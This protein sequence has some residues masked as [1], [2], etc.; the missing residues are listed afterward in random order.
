MINVINPKLYEAK[1]GGKGLRFELE[2]RNAE[3]E[4]GMAVNGCRVVN[5]ALL[6]P[7]ITLKT[8]RPYAQVKFHGMEAD[9][10]AAIDAAG[11][12]RDFPAVVFP[13]DARG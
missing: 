2:L 8:G 6:G 1:S 9:V 10:L 7:F 11:W 12:R 13:G 4:L 3:G 5:G